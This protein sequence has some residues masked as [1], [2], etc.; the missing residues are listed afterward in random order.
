MES[1]DL[2]E[3]QQSYNRNGVLLC[4][5]GPLTKSL[6]EEIGHAL[7][8]YM[9]NESAS[10]SMDVFAAYIEMTQNIRHYAASQGWTEQES[11]ATVVISQ[12]GDGHY[13]VSA[14]NTVNAEDGPPLVARIEALA[15][16]DKPQLKA[17]YK[18]QLRKPREEGSASGAGL[19]LLDIAR[20]ASSPFACS[21]RELGNG[22]AFFTLIATI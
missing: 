11:S 3:L 9:R 15:S 16:L 12:N 21:L 14:G 19:G 1:I 4:F 5:N 20:K 13:V 17:A 7:R 18:D 8:N 22:R 2:Y 10:T 6:I